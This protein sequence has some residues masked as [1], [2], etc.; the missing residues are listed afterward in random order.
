MSDFEITGSSMG[1]IIRLDRGTIATNEDL[2]KIDNYE[3]IRASGPRSF[4]TDKQEVKFLDLS[5]RDSLSL[6]D[7]QHEEL[8][9]LKFNRSRK[10]TLTKTQSED[11]EKLIKKRDAKPQLSAGGKTEVEKRF[12][13]KKFDFKKTFTSKYT[14]KGN[15]KE[16]QSIK[17]FVKHLGLPMVLKNEKRYFNEWTNGIP[18]T[19]FKSFN[20][21]MDMKNVYYP[22]NL[23]TFE[24]VLD[25]DYIWQQH[26]Y[27]WIVPVQY[28]LVVK[29]LLNPPES[30]LIKEA[31]TLLKQ[32][33]LSEMTDDFMEEVREYFNF[34]KMPIEDRINIY[35]IETTEDHIN[36]MKQ[37]VKLA[38]EYWSVLEVKWSVKNQ[39]EIEFIKGLI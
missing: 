16:D 4:L 29:I 2:I 10:P 23:D 18:D 11:L 7:K 9:K 38:R 28:G 14:D 25:H 5:S 27:N 21:Q 17:D 6:S 31:W 37:A 32:A 36:Q 33:G 15:I 24:G 13:A 3:E 26:T 22:E 35:T 30:I 8:E 39:N 34:E 19:V 20:F 1:K 12:Y